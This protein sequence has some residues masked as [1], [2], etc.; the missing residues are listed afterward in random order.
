MGAAGG[1]G[2][3][4]CAGLRGLSH[5]KTH[6]R[7]ARHQLAR[8]RRNCDRAGS[9]SAERTGPGAL[10]VARARPWRSGWRRELRVRRGRAR[11]GP[12]TKVVASL[13]MVAAGG[14]VSVGHG[15]DDTAVARSI[16]GGA[17]RVVGLA[18]Q[19]TDG[20]VRGMR[21]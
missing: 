10:T 14:E 17:W 8:G 7:L 1:A 4:G 6:D 3:G 2:G 18:R 16:A 21:V 13:G 5:S 9:G 19:T 11:W 12:E 15:G 20:P